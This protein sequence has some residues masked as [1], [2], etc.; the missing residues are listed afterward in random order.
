MREFAA[1]PAAKRVAIDPMQAL[2]GKETPETL[3]ALCERAALGPQSRRP[4]AAAPL[5]LP[6]AL[7]ISPPC[8]PLAHFC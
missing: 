7:P 2:E 3:F 6:S 5:S 4:G 8:L 1:A